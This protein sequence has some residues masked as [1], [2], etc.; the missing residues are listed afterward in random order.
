MAQSGENILPKSWPL[1]NSLPRRLPQAGERGSF[2]EDRGDRHHAGI[3]LYAEPGTLVVAVDGGSVL[4]VTEFTSPE[5]LPYWNRTVSVLVRH[6]D[7]TVARYAE[8]SDACVS[9]GQSVRA[10]QTVGSVGVV[11]NLA[12]IG[13]NSPAYIQGLKGLG[14]AAML[15]LELYRRPPADDSHYLGGNFFRPTP[16]PD[17]LDPTPWLSELLSQPAEPMPESG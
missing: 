4:A 16:P 5:R 7:G 1:L 2:W 15:H 12:E 3:D 14:V 10:G 13:P 9:P 8:M 17:L 6:A 11:L